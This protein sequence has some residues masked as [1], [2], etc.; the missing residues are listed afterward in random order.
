MYLNVQVKI[1]HGAQPKNRNCPIRL[2]YSGGITRDTLI[3]LARDLGV[4]VEE[5]LMTRDELYVADEVFLCGTA[6]EVTP[7]R[8]IDDRRIWHRATR[9]NFIINFKDILR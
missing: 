6:A 9:R 8:E 3:T 1:F 5:R 2:E 4:V 7:V